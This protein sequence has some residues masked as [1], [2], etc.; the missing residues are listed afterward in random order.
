MAFG[1]NKPQSRAEPTF[2]FVAGRKRDAKNSGDKQDDIGFTIPAFL[3]TGPASARTDKTS[4]VDFKPAPKGERKAKTYKENTPAFR[5]SAT[6][7]PATHMSKKNKAAV[8]TKP[9]TTG[10]FD[11]D[12]AR[13]AETA[14][15]KYA[16][17]G[18]DEQFEPRYTFRPAA[19]TPPKTTRPVEA[20][21]SDNDQGGIFFFEEPD[22]EV[23]LGTLSDD[24]GTEHPD[25]EAEFDYQGEEDDPAD[26]QDASYFAG[27]RLHIQ[28]GD[29]YYVPNHARRTRPSSFPIGS[30]LRLV[31][32][33]GIGLFA[34]T[35]FWPEKTPDRP[36]SAVAAREVPA[37]QTKADARTI[38]PTGPGQWTQT[39]EASRAGA[40]EALPDL[41]VAEVKPKA[42]VPKIR[43]SEK[44]SVPDNKPERNAASSEPAQRRHVVLAPGPRP[45]SPYYSSGSGGVNLLNNGPSERSRSEREEAMLSDL[46]VNVQRKLAVLGYADVPQTGQLDAATRGAIR[47]FQLNSG[48]PPTG[49]VDSQTLKLM[50]SMS[51]IE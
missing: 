23:A 15:P 51:H 7:P 1:R 14:K 28:S 38:V 22:D 11:N 12:F 45:L 8:Q 10:L 46:A 25:D 33:V 50:S 31:A 21:H 13:L 17:D 30:R 44:T 49:E 32:A 27:E 16:V 24:D 26:W 42:P 9:A 39:N 37:A 48:L 43:P 36:A 41:R 18:P 2:V 35:Y 3:R 20:E 34:V 5:S 4:F 40:E 29:D 19:S 47:S 6:E